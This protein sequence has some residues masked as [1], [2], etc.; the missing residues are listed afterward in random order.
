M[1]DEAG[2]VLSVRRQQARRRRVRRVVVA[3]LVALAVL[4]AVWIVGFSTVLGVRDVQVDGAS[5]VTASD[6]QTAAAVPSGT[7]LIRVDQNAV[8]SRV[9][10]A[11]PEVA[12]VTVSRHWPG[13]VVIH[14]TERST[15]FQVLDGGVYHWIS[16]DGI[17]FH[18]SQASQSVPT[19]AVGL[20]DQQLLADL[21][22]VVASL[23][24]DLASPVVSV[25]AET[26]DSITLTLDDGR[27]VVWGSADQSALKA[28]VIVPLLNVPGKVYDVSAPS[29]PAVRP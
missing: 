17:D 22:T 4:A 15:V 3:G 9:V 10:A 14:V 25:T 28:Q 23:P 5:L 24:A 12:T 11:L 13:T 21:A 6:V 8:A 26:R 1:P 2:V 16:A 20:D 7:P 18:T 27:Q 19:A 29:N